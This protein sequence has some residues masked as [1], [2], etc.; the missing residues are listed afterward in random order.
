MNA[1][2]AARRV[3]NE[4]ELHGD[5]GDRFAE[6]CRIVAQAVLA[7]G[8]CGDCRYWEAQSDRDDGWC[9]RTQGWWALDESCSRYEPREAGKGGE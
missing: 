4:V 2:D 6:D 3:L 5:D 1:Q 7:Q 8:T 9:P